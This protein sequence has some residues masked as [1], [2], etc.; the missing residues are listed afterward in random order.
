MGVAAYFTQAWL[1]SVFAEPQIW[2]RV[3]RVGGAIGV[4]LAV[5]AASAHLLRLEEF[6]AA[7]SRVVGRLRR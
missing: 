7:M 4:A 5:L 6:G 2:H 3:I 1:E